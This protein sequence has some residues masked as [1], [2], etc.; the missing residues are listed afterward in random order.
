MATF[1]LPTV[2]PRITIMTKKTSSPNDQRSNTKNPTNPAYDAD[3][4]NRIRQGRENAAPPPE[5]S[6]APAGDVKGK[7]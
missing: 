1:L 3:Q 2:G 5:P 6:Q 4:A 7:H